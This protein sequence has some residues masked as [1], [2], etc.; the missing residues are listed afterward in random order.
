[1]SFTPDPFWNEIYN[2]DRFVYGT[3]PNEYLAEKAQE[4]IIPGA[5]VLCIADG[6][7]RNGVFLAKQHACTVVAFDASDVAMAKAQKFIKDSGVESEVTY[8]LSDCDSFQ[9]WQPDA[10]DAI[11]GIFIQFADH[12]MR[13]R[14]FSRVRSSLRPGGVFIL[15]GYTPKQLEFKT[16]GPQSLAPCYTEEMIRELALAHDLEITELRC[17]EAVLSEGFKHSGMSALLGLTARRPQ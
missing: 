17:Y 4:C 1:M 12:E 15:Q 13:Q 8:F 11:V 2:Q 14:I 6:E 10:Y 5:T 16:G 7:G 9:G 3:L